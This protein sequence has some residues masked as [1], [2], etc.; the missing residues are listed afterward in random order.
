MAK[1]VKCSSRKAKRPCPALAVDIC[2]VCCA[3]NRLIEIPCPQDCPFLQGEFYQHRRRQERAASHGR[4]FLA[5]QEK[6]FPEEG[7]REFAFR[8]QADVYYYL[9]KNGPLDDRTMASA[10]DIVKGALSKIFV[11]PDAP[12]PI[13][14][15]LT[16]RLS[17]ARRYPDRGPGFSPEERR[18]AVGALASHI[19]S[20]A[21][22]GSRRYHEILAGFFDSLDFEADLDY[23]PEDAAA[24]DSGPEGPPAP[25]R[26]PSGLILPP[27]VCPTRPE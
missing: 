5:L 9:R 20:L 21:R 16:T 3:E 1:C 17:D 12:I 8:L 7:P 19:R 22:D 4:D 26:S 25:R 2:P 14:L 27:G 10:F 11:P 24:P 18:R 15:F 6:L 23:S 13:A